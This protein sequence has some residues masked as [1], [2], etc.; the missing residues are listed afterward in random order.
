MAK[1][2]ED[3]NLD[4]SQD[5]WQAPQVQPQKTNAPDP[6]SP[7]EIA[8]QNAIYG[9]GGTAFKKPNA[10]SVWD[11][12]TE[13]WSQGTAPAPTTAGGGNDVR[14]YIAQLAAMPGA[15]PSLASNP[16][17]WEEAIN[18]RGGLNAGNRQFWQDASV[19]PTAFF[20][21][22]N[23]EGG[24]AP[25][26]AAGGGGGSDLSSFLQQMLMANGGNKTDPARTA[27]MGRLNTMMDQYSQP[28]SAT[29]ANIAGPTQAYTGQVGRSV[30][31]FKKQAAERAYAEGVP[32]GAFDSQVGGATMAG[33]RSIGDFETNQMNTEMQ[34]RRASLM[35]TLT[36]AGNLL[37]AQDQ[38]DIQNKI[39]N[40]DAV[41]K[42]KG[43]DLT[44]KG[45]DI[46]NKGLDI[47]KMLGLLG[48]GNTTTSIN[49]QNSQFYDK[50]GADE[51]DKG[52]SL[53]QILSDLLLGG[54]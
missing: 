24:G 15:D 1:L 45:L 26:P 50:L 30:N 14:A 19:G 2:R 8:R 12:Q 13:T 16:D 21:N 47:Q 46:N 53:D 25:A 17:Y 4:F 5:D 39:A 54:K 11:P 29:D 18:S 27:L 9:P 28:V 34:S 6:N 38:A 3:G 7:E 22:P 10:D 20:N 48:A 51:A 49:N 43:L 41:M 32:T 31:A 44:D 35:S 40:I 42:S 36:S 23:R 33:G 37:S 52:S